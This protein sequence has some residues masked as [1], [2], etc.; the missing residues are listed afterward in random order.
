MSLPSNHHHFISQPFSW[1]ST[2]LRR[3]EEIFLSN[4][5][6]SRRGSGEAEGASMKN[7]SFIENYRSFSLIA[8]H[9]P[10]VRVSMTTATFYSRAM[11]ALEIRGGSGFRF[12]HFQGSQRDTKQNLICRIN[13]FRVIARRE[14]RELH[15]AR[16]GRKPK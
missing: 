2:H 5:A 10:S 1:V 6:E 7:V 16:R 8:P 13:C 3:G 11:I 9:P 14:L 15:P 4:G 12:I